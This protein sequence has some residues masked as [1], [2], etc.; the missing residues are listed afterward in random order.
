MI[1]P[2][3]RSLIYKAFDEQTKI[4]WILLR[5]GFLAKSWG[6][7]IEPHFSYIFDKEGWEMSVIRALFNR[8]PHLWRLRC[9]IATASDE[10]Y[11]LH[12]RK[13]AELDLA[14]LKKNNHLVSL[15]HNLLRHPPGYFNRAS[16]RT[17][18]HWNTM[19]R[20]AKKYKKFIFS[21]L[22]TH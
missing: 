3:M 20:E 7:A 15:Y 19:I 14:F 13:D 6:D 1:E 8:S 22:K 21:V 9:K 4:G 2:A 5:K 11:L 12:L 10:S 18:L 17:I 16:K